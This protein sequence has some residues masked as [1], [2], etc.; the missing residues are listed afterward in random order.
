MSADERRQ[1]L[2]R[3]LPAVQDLLADEGLADVRSTV[4]RPLFVA[5]VQEEIASLRARLLADGFGSVSDTDTATATGPVGSLTLAA[6]VREAVRARAAREAE[7]WPRPVLNATGVIV[8]TNLGRAPLADDAIDHLRA[9]AVGYS[10]LEYDLERG[11]RGSRQSAVEGLLTTL[12]DAEAAFA[13]NNNAAAVLLALA[14]HVTETRSEVI[15]SR[16]ELVE[17]GGSFRVPDVLRASG[18]TLVEV[19]TT[20]R[21]H[22][23]DYRR[24]VG[25]ATAAILKV[26]PSNF[27]VVGFTA[28]VDEAALGTLAAEAHVPLICDAGSGLVVDDGTTPSLRDEPAPRRLVRHAT[29]V[30][31]SG[32]KLLGGP[33]AGIL[34]G[35]GPAIAAAKRHPLARAVR[36]DKLS[37]AALASTLR[38]AIDPARAGEIPVVRMLRE[39]LVAVRARAEAVAAAIGVS[40]GDWGDSPRERERADRLATIDVVPSEAAVGGGS[41]PG[42]TLPSFAVRIDVGEASAARLEKVLR[43]G[44]VPVVARVREGAV[45]L[46]VRTIADREVVAL[47]RAAAEA[48]HRLSTGRNRTRPELN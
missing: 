1:A 22:L 19:G 10:T 15:V 17:I 3:E 8:H 46:D 34:A 18:A 32:D 43:Q 38:L 9:V 36:I 27:R 25:P 30:T 14:A 33:Q 41:V 23:H 29:L 28:E 7:A 31:F 12:L 24:A 11:E 26:H 21:T 47:A 40:G 39:P 42:Q 48:I 2:L 13:V 35:R 4:P 5:I 37:L 44:A 16:G 45:L 20:N 6:A